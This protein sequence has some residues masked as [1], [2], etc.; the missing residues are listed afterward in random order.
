MTRR[1]SGTRPPNFFLAG[2]PKAGTT[3]LHH[4]LNQHPQVFMSPIKEP[5]FFGA[6]DLLGGPHGERVRTLLARDRAALQ[7]YLQGPQPPEQFRFVLTWDE[8]LRLFRDSGQATA[9]GESST[10]YFYLPS[11]P[12]AI[13]A[14]LPHAQVVIVLRDPADWL[15]TRYLPHL[16]AHPR[17]SF[18]EWLRTKAT[19]RRLGPSVTGI[20]Q[21]STHLRRFY[22]TFPRHQLTV[23]LYDE[24]QRDAAQV[25]RALCKFLGVRPDHPVDVSRRHNET[26]V[27]RFPRLHAARRRLFGSAS[28]TQWL[29]EPVGRMVR[30]AYHRRR[31]RTRMAPEDRRM[32][33][34]MYRDDIL[35]TADL[36]G[37]DLSAWL[38]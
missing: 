33:I 1:T 22:D 4:Y 8:Y 21:Y 34:D 9:I 31:G 32:V 7:S 19:L 5:T 25:L 13:R 15:F 30:G 2:V 10:A 35:R 28:A 17:V 23:L 11:A 38:R 14:K 29:P 36:I 26:L 16:Q 24:Y 3:S 18:R 12:R 37:R 6:A 27:P 20:A